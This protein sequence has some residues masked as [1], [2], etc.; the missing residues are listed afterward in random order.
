MIWDRVR[1]HAEQVEMFRRAVR[2]NRMTHSF[3]FHGPSGIGKRLFAH[4]LAQ[5]LFCSRVPDEDLDACGECGHCR[6]MQAG[7]HADF[8][9]KRCPD[10][11]AIF[12]MELLAGDQEHRGREG[13]C[14]ELSLRPHSSERRIAVIDD[15]DRFNDAAANAFL[16]TL[17]EPP[18]YATLI[19]LSED[20]AAQLPTI[21]SRCQHVRFSPLCNRDIAELLLQLGWADQSQE[22]DA[23]A[24]ICD[25][26]LTTA[27]QL[28]QPEFRELRQLIRSTLA[29]GDFHSAHTADAVMKIVSACGDTP[30]QR[31]AALWAV[32]FC[33]DFFA[34]Q[35]RSGNPAAESFDEL[36]LLGQ[37]IERA[38]ETT[39][40]I[41]GNLQVPLALQTMFHD[42]SRIRR[43]PLLI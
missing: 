30:A 41:E 31:Q 5:C 17:E 13:L 8:H 40:Q 2:R 37:L 36:E 19:L 22:A 7:T 34:E 1:G 32:R 10:G 27:S 25:G 6:Q 29:D 14:Y 4:T 35:I 3:L 43:S 16:K 39:R 20:P 23:V 33:I 26:S 9:E 28:L 15:A 42:L 24:E 11:K 38:A 12:P 21:R 18:P